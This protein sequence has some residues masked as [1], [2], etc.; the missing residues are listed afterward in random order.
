MLFLY[1]R[2]ANTTG[3]GRTDSHFPL[4]WS[5]DSDD[6]KE[7]IWGRMTQ[8]E[9][10]FTIQALMLLVLTLL[11]LRNTGSRSSLSQ[12][13]QDTRTQERLLVF[14]HPFH[15]G[16]FELLFHLQTR[17][18]NKNLDIISRKESLEGF[19]RVSRVCNFDRTAS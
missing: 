17:V 7:R 18:K 11:C 14:P 8:T 16:F 5:Y 12:D 13:S 2:N 1:S 3:K 10:I 6:G 9:D 19:T 4:D 15:L